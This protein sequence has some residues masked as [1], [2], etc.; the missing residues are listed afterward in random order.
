MKNCGPVP[1]Q[2]FYLIHDN[3]DGTADVYLRPDTT[4]R[5]A[6]GLVSLFVV[7][8]VPMQEG[9]EEDIRAR[10]DAWCDSGDNIVI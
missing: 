9:L 5:T 4:D 6:T 8:N 1:E 3:K 7:K 2:R 10:Y